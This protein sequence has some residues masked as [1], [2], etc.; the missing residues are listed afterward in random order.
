MSA[1]KS[2]DSSSKRKHSAKPSRGSADLV[3][4]R[5]MSERE[6]AQTSPVELD[7]L[8][9]EFWESATLVDPR[10]PKRES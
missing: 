3:R 2:A 9:P 5:S 8:P 10:R 6:I 1:R 4:I 7:D